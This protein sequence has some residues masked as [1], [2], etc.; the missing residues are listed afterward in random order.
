MTT[1]RK[2]HQIDAEGMV[3]GRLA[4]RVALLLVGKSKPGFV[5]NLDLGD[6]VVVMN[7]N[8]IVMTG[9]KIGAKVFTRYSGYPG[10]L[11]KIPASKLTSQALIR[12][13]VLGMLPNNK[14]KPIW[15]K[16]LT[17]EL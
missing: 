10:G 6:F 15:I 3:L 1:D 4:T 14:L 13:A 2:T 9:K 12:H 11:S 17:F 16:R 7:S 5:R 8:K